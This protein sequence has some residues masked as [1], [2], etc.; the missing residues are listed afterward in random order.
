MAK[1]HDLLFWSTSFCKNEPNF[2]R[3]GAHW[4]WKIWRNRLAPSNVDQQDYPILGAFFENFLPWNTLE[5]IFT[6]LLTYQ[7]IW[8]K[9]G[10]FY[11]TLK[12]LFRQLKMA[13]VWIKMASFVKFLIVTKWHKTNKVLCLSHFGIF[14]LSWLA[15]F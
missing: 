10:D 1:C 2:W 5:W 3:L 11:S 14:I 7:T 12:K 9:I 15:L 8:W 6:F 13:M 4:V